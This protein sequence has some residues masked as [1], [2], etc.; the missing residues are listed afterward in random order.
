[1]GLLAEL[2][3]LVT[4]EGRVFLE[5]T[6]CI[7]NGSSED[8]GVKGECRLLTEARSTSSPGSCIAWFEIDLPNGCC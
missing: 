6:F 8:F 4:E 5:P 1:M 2:G 7:N 3:F